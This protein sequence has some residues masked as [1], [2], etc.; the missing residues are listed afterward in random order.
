M[1]SDK[2]LIKFF[3]YC[4]HFFFSFGLS[5]DKRLFVVFFKRLFS[6]FRQKALAFKING[7]KCNL[8]IYLSIYWIIFAISLR[9]VTQLSTYSNFTWN[10]SWIL[11]IWNKQTLQVLIKKRKLNCYNTAQNLEMSWWKN[12]PHHVNKRNYISLYLYQFLSLPR[13]KI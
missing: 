2:F 6:I 1:K 10:C 4:R 9:A 11:K 7:E 12:N 3:N 8:F 13:P 5:H